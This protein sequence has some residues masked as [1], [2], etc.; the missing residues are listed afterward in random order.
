MF[1][2]KEVRSLDLCVND[3]EVFFNEF[4]VTMNRSDVLPLFQ[5]HK[6]PVQKGSITFDQH[7]INYQQKTI[8][9]Q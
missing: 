9:N 8:I 4:L 2:A 5:S 7:D 6:I 1:K 3:E